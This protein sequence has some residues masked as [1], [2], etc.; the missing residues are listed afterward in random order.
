M[1]PTLWTILALS[2]AAGLA[3]CV[4]REL[5]ITSEP[6]GALVQV[7]DVTVGRTPVIMPFTWYGDYEIIVRHEGEQGR[8][9]RTLKTH[10]NINPPIYEIPPLDL[11]SALAPWTYHDTRYLHYE[12]EPLEAPEPDEI[13]ERAR[14]LR[15]ET[16]Q[17]VR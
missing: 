5:V 2:A 6:Q 12:L 14:E 17:R 8:P 4:E 1:K 11:L 3:G 10:A 7:S 13:I 9:Y 15:E 16:L